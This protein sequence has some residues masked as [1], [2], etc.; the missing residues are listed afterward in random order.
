M[1]VGVTKEIAAGEKRVAAT[2]DT[3]KKLKEKL[4]FEVLVEKDAGLAASFFDSAY[5][6]IG[7]KVVGRDEVWKAD[8]VLKVRAPDS[9]EVS[10]LSEGQVILSL[11]HI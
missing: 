9:D 7:C 10:R 8:V 1:R 5:E 4:G 6:A 11:I 2:P 3:A